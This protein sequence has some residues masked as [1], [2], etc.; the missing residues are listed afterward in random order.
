M[1]GLLKIALEV[2]PLGVFFVANSRFGIFAATGAFMVATIISLTVSAIVMKRLPI[3]PLVTGVFVIVFGGLTIYLQNET[4]IKVKPTIVNLLFAA[5]L[6]TGLLF[7]RS[8]MKI[9]L[10]EVIQLRDE[11]WRLFTL[12]WTAFFLALALLNEIVWRLFSTETWAA[13]KL[14]GVMPITFLFMMSQIGLLQKY[15]LPQEG[16]QPAEK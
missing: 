1:H 6:G 3:M 11:G 5:A 8:L 10:G 16:A 14:F 7:G 12:R 15:Q 9:I 4:F 2:G 13:F